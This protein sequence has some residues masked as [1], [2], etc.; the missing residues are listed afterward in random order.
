MAESD[1]VYTLILGGGAGRRLF[2]LTQDRAK[3]AVPLAGKFRLID[4]PISNCINSKLGKIF[5]V[6]QFNSQ[7]MHRHI[8]NAYK[9]DIFSD[10]FV[11]ILAAEQTQQRSEWFQGTADAVRRNLWHLTDP[12]VDRVLILSGDQ[13]YRMDFR[14][15]IKTHAENRAEVTVA[16]TLRRPDRVEGLGILKIDRHFRVIDFVEKPDR[17]TLKNLIIQGEDLAPLGI[18]A[19][20]PV[21]LAS[22]GIYMFNRN[23]LELAL[24]NEMD[25]FGRNVI[26]WCI[27]HMRVFVHPFMGYWEDVGTIRNFF[28]VNIDL[29]NQVP[30]FDFYEQGRP[31]YTHPRFLPNAKV[32]GDSTVNSCI[33]SDG[34]VVNNSILNRCVIGIRSIVNSGCNLNE[35]IMMG[36]DRYE[37]VEECEECAGLPQR[38]L[39]KG[40][41]ISHAIIDKNARIGDGVVITNHVGKPNEDGDCYCVRDGIVIIPKNAIVPDGRKI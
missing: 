30:K 15:I 9:F 21:V 13:L 38:G 4:V 8:H 27:Q 3:P 29:T 1:K 39:G 35:V 2:P 24:D 16:A 34:A 36:Q 33:L 14:D 17:A 37:T 41:N 31:I 28:D 25:D 26:P 40:C 12:E 23:R 10:S 5:V 32:C 7:S 18:K 20:G 19:E 11:E 22:M 6:T